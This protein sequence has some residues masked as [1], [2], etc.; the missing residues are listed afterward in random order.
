MKSLFG[1]TIKLHLKLTLS[2]LVGM[3][4]PKTIFSLCLSNTLCLVFKDESLPAC[5]WQIGI[6]PLMF[7]LSFMKCFH[8]VGHFQ[9][10]QIGN[11]WNNQNQHVIYGSTTWI[12]E[13]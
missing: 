3:G 10:G 2:L 7:L 1:K 5:N 13:T 9:Y 6:L 4:F 8:T 11:G 12:I